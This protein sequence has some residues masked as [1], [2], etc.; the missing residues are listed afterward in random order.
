MKIIGRVEEQ[1]VLREYSES[2]MPE[3]IVVYG[4]NDFYIL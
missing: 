3:F 4:R 2:K 1:A